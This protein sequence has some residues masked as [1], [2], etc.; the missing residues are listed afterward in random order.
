MHYVINFYTLIVISFVF[1]ACSATNIKV[2]DNCDGNTDCI[3]LMSEMKKINIASP[4]VDVI[5]NIKN[6][7][8]SF[9]GGAFGYACTAPGVG[10]RGHVLVQKYGLLCIDGI[11]DHPTSR[12]YA[13]K[14][15]AFRKYASEYNHKLIY[16]C[17]NL[18]ECDK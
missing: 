10:D 6:G 5:N 3:L 8:L 2:T 7:K 15:D 4:E 1:S 14:V 16:H 18:K 17:E 9:V 11:T 12:E 13:D